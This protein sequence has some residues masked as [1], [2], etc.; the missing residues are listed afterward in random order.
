M[1][2]IKFR[3]DIKLR[4]A[5]NVTSLKGDVMDTRI[6]GGGLAMFVGPDSDDCLAIMEA[7]QSLGFKF[8]RTESFHEAKQVILKQP[9]ELLI[10]NVRLGAFNGLHLVLHGKYKHPE[11][12]AIMIADVADSGLEAEARKMDAIMIHRGASRE[13]WIATARR[14]TDI[15]AR[16]VH[17][18]YH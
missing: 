7:L 5:Y 13:E 16:T 1:T 11:M 6:T 18:T 8:I 4:K 14:A 17:S 15:S 10:S 3:F 12:T 2:L 9:L